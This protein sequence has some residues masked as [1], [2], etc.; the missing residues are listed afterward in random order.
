MG[1]ATDDQ[2]K[3]KLV[4]DLVEEFPD[5]FEEERKRLQQFK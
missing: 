3:F 1:W 5:R 2:T 4:Q